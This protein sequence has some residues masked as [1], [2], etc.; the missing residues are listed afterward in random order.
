M[1]LVHKDK[2]ERNEKNA[3]TGKKDASSK[4]VHSGLGVPKF[5]TKILVPQICRKSGQKNVTSCFKF[6]AHVPRTSPPRT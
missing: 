5:G 4:H 2:E 1:R 6:W 3:Q